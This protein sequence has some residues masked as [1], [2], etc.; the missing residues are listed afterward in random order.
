MTDTTPEFELRDLQPSRTDM[1]SDIVNGLSQPE[2]WISSMYFYDE[3]GSQLF[4]RI[5]ETP[6]YY[7][8]RTELAIMQGNIQAMCDRLG[9][10]V[11]LIE[12]GSGTSEKVRLLLRH[13][14]SPVAYVPV[15]IA[16]EHLLAA[17]E[18]INA[19]FPELEVLPV[20]ADFTQPWEVPLA[21]RRAKRRALYFPGSTIGNFEPPDALELL[22]NMRERADGDGALLIGVDMRKDPMI[23]ERAYN[24]AEG[25]TAQFNL[26][27][28][29]RINRE[30]GA[31]FDLDSFRHEALWN[32]DES[33]IEMHLVSLREQTARIGDAEFHFGDGERIHTESSYKYTIESF[34][35]LAAKA[36]FV[37]REVWLD[38]DALFSVR[39]LETD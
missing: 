23:L 32:G 11:M 9:P 38:D 25:I 27:V 20:C 2:K 19:E 14:D 13:L 24:D 29:R 8:T 35:E 30:L 21:T 1:R 31:D 7:P 26:N 36:G 34:A 17:A 37:Q 22:R 18:S 3:Y 33:R 10:D 16:R 15:E 4:D 6:E 39:Y 5:C 12:P 28:L